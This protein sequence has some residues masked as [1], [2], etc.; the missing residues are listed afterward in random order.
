L[1]IQPAGLAL[2]PRDLRSRHIRIET[3]IRTEH[4]MHTSEEV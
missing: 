4:A 3:H 1:G 2:Q